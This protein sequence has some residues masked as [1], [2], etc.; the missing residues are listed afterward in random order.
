MDVK[1]L[2][3]KDVL[4]QTGMGETRLAT[5]I[6]ESKFPAPLKLGPRSS[7]WPSD[8]VQGWIHDQIRTSRALENA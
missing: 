5:L 4:E 8:Q 2:R 6:K 7:R 1:L 3:R